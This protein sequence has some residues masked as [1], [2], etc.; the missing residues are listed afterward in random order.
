M[1]ENIHWSTS[2]GPGLSLQS[3]NS[4]VSTAGGNWV[5]GGRIFPSLVE[6][7]TTF[8]MCWLRFLPQLKWCLKGKKHRMICV[9]NLWIFRNLLILMILNLWRIVK[10][11]QLYIYTL[12][13][14][15]RGCKLQSHPTVDVYQTQLLVGGFKHEIYFPFHIWDVILPID[16][17]HHFS[18][19]LLHH[20]PGYY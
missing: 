17:L 7:T 16:E 12:P 1:L 2:L 8:F 4:L 5:S 6:F 10:K 11:L 13:D 19:W 14:G 20:Q 15:R 9:R 3:L 18:R